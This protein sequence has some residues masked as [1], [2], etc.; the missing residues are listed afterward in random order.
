M[1]ARLQAG[2]MRAL[3]MTN[4]S[5]P[6]VLADAIDPVATD[7][8][9]SLS[10]PGCNYT[11]V[12]AAPLGNGCGLPVTVAPIGRLDANLPIGVQ[13]V[14]PYLQDRTPIT[15]AEGPPDPTG[16]VRTPPCSDNFVQPERRS[17]VRSSGQ[18]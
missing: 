17:S 13:I 4:R 12:A 16:M 10:R 15:M 9:A 7:F 3:R 2:F 11:G 18:W 8:V 14:G 5:V 6:V 1:A